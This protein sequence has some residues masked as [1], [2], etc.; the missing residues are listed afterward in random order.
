MI[1]LGGKLAISKE[2]VVRIFI[3]FLFFIGIGTY[4]LLWKDEFFWN[5]ILLSF[6]LGTL[7]FEF[8]KESPSPLGFY[9]LFAGLIMLLGGGIFLTGVKD[10]AA[11]GETTFLI[12]FMKFFGLFVIIGFGIVSYALAGLLLESYRRA[13]KSRKQH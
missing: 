12:D 2:K 6:I 9:F 3:A 7:I 10:E 4:N 1:R 5:L 13:S 11:A 8:E